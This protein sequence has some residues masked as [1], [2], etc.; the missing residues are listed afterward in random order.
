[1]FINVDKLSDLTRDT[2]LLKAKTKEFME[3]DKNQI[4][5]LEKLDEE[6]S[7]LKELISH[8][9]AKNNELQR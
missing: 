5:R 3:K 8:L 1:M 7:S 2:G 4:K 6:T 9:E